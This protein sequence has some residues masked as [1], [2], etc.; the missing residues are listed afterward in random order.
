MS[1]TTTVNVV[2]TGRDRVDGRLKV[3]GAATYP[4]DVSDAFARPGDGWGSVA[5]VQLATM[6]ELV[7]GTAWQTR[8]SAWQPG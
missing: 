6:K 2:G 5:G 3:M 1:A 4:I 7:L 8:Q